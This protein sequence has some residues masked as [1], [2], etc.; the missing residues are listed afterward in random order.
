MQF[1][2]SAMKLFIP[3]IKNDK[4]NLWQAVY[5]ERCKYGFG[6]SVVLSKVMTDCAYLMKWI[7]K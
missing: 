4:L 2:Q 3:V 7:M 1:A 5:I 6:G